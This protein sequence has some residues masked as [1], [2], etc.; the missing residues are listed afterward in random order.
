MHAH[1]HTHSGDNLHHHTHPATTPPTE[2][3]AHAGVAVVDDAGV[4]TTPWDAD[5]AWH[6]GSESEDPAKFY[7]GI[8]AGKRNGDPSTQA[9]WAL[10]YKYSPSA[11]PNAGGVRAALARLNQTQGLINKADAQSTLQA[12]MKKVNPDYKPGDQVDGA[13]LSAVLREL[14]RGGK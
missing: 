12:A 5:K 9:A 3:A 11:A 7:E 1:E 10:P 14:V 8:C 6:A 2:V 4:D 13:L